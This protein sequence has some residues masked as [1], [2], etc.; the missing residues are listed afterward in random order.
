[1]QKNIKL[2][3]VVVALFS[4]LYAD[5][6][7]TIE[8]KPLTI[9]STAIKTDELKSTDAVE[10]YTKEDIQ[11]S[12]AKDIYEFLNTQTSVISMPSYGNPFAQK[13]DMRGYGTTDGYQNIVIKVNGRKLNNVDMVPQLLS[14]ISPSSIEKIEIIKSSGIVEG[15]DGTNGGVINI[16]TKKTDEKEISFYGGLYKAIDGSFYVGHRDEKLSISVNGEAQSNGGIR[17][18]N[19]DGKRD[20]NKF[21]NLGFELSYAPIEEIELRANALTSDVDVIY[22]GSMKEDEY[23]HNPMQEGTK[24]NSWSGA[25][26]DSG[27]THQT[28]SSDVVGVGASYFIN[29]ELS[30]NGDF[31]HEF[32]DSEYPDYNFKFKYIYNSYNINTLYEI[33]NLSIKAGLDGFKGKRDAASNSTSKDNLAGYITA[34]Y[35]FK[36]N[37][38][39]AGY[40]YEEVVYRYD[41]NAGTQLK[42]THYLNGVELGYNYLL[43]QDM[44]LFANY[45]KGYQAPDIDRFFSTIYP[46]PTYAP[47]ISFNGFIDPAKSDNYNVGFNYIT[48]QNKLK[49]TAYYI[50]LKDEI[51]YYNNNGVRKN[52]NI[53]KSHKLGLDLYDKYIINNE[54]NVVLNYNYVQAIIDDEKEGGDDYS[55]NTLPGVSDHNIKATLSYM[56][57]QYATI[58]LTQVYRTEAYAAEDFNNDFD[59]K[60]DAYNSTDISA[61]YAKDNWEVFGK[62]NNLFNQKNG[63]WIKDDVVYPVNFTTTALVGLKLKY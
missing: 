15:G 63:L 9:T 23:N 17:E 5:E 2:S 47:V 25:W 11:K 56:P 27:S 51:Y 33:E 58:S 20:K 22:A 26:I 7:K 55:G 49:V 43:N 38:F 21:S 14:S 45:S 61:T 28:Y 36:N 62:I 31:S 46:P 54:F 42:S 10:V 3:L 18:I 16:I 24:Y 57:N 19:A 13:L 4:S 8:L 32:K 48:K 52:T 50:D 37:S 29:D 44:S 35:N 12:H 30:I 59:Q 6:A 34:S 53:D 39:K 60:Q 41:P 40:R 1:M